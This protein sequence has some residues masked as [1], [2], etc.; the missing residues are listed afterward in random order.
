MIEFL[1]WASCLV[2]FHSW[3]FH[4]GEFRTC[5]DCG[6]SEQRVITVH[7]APRNVR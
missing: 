2:G 6:R 5:R 3:R 4:G 1:R 7:W